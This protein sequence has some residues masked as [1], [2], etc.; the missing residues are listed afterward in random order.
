VTDILTRGFL[1][2]DPTKTLP[3]HGLVADTAFPVG[4]RLFQHI[5]SPLKDGEADTIH[6]RSLRSRLVQQ[7]RE[8]TSLRQACEWGM[9]SIQ[10]PFK[11]L[12]VHLPWRTDVRAVRLSNIFR[13]W[14][15]RV[16][17][18]G[19]SQIRESFGA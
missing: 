8:I 16:R 18:T 11:R 15:V 7:S 10:K 3:G 2:I 17:S 4:P 6:P 19:I 13:L 9:G 12:M 14:N 1:Y 5:V